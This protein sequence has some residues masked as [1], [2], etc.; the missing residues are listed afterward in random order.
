[1]NDNFLLEYATFL[2]DVKQKIVTARY[3]ALKSV[4]SELINLYRDIGNI[5]V[6]KQKS[7]LWGRSLV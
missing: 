5:I 2:Q 3:Q 4:N 6:D 1:M 7:S